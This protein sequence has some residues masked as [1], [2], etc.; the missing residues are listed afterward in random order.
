MWY[1]TLATD[2]DGTLCRGR[3]LTRRTAAALSRLREAGGK[4]ILVTGEIYDQFRDLT[5]TGLFD[6]VVGENGGVLYRPGQPGAEPLGE[7]MPLAIV[8]AL[9]RR[10]VEPVTL[11]QALVSTKCPH[12]DVLRAALKEIGLNWRL[13]FNR[14]SVMALPR[15]VSKATGVAAALRDLGVPARRAVGVGDAENDADLLRACGFG[16]AVADAVPK[17]RGMAD[18]VTEH[19]GPAGVAELVERMLADDLP[20]PAYRAR[21]SAS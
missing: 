21:R 8:P 5:E 13:V 14:R 18:W 9:L 12:A 3:R 7:T 19:R 2:S 6:R 16:V 10:G 20:R 11:G 1:L 15:N 4:V 17:L